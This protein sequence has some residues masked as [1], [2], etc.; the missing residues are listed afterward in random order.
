[1]KGIN[2]GGQA[3]D[4]VAEPDEFNNL[5]KEPSAQEALCRLREQVI[6]HFMPKV[7]P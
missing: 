7:L 2:T 1:M 5:I 6:E 4:T 3:L